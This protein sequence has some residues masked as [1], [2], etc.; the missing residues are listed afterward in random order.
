MRV[1]SKGMQRL[2]TGTLSRSL[3]GLAACGFSGSHIYSGGSIGKFIWTG[4]RLMLLVWGLPLLLAIAACGDGASTPAPRAPSPAEVQTGTVSGRVVSAG[5]G[6][7]IAG[8]TVSVGSATATTVADGSYTL[9]ADAGERVVLHVEAPSF[10]ENFRIT[11]IDAGQT[12]QLGGAQLLPIGTTQTITVA[13]G[14]T[15]AVPN[16]TAQVIIPANA[17]VPRT[18]GV[19]AAAVNVSVTPINPSIDVNY[20]PGDFTTVPAGGGTPIQI[21]TFGAQYVDIRDNSG[22]RYNLAPNTTATI[23]IPVG[24]R[25]PAQPRTIPLFYFDDS[26]GRWVE[27]GT[28]I[29]GGTLPNQYYEGTVSRLSYWNADRVQETVF[30]SGCVQDAAGQRVSNALVQTDGINYSGSASSR[31]AAD[32]SFRVALQRNSLATLVA[33]EGARITSTASVGPFSADFTMPSCLVLSSAT[34]GLSIKLTWGAGPLD[35]DSHLFVPNGNHVYFGNKGSLVNLPHANLDVDDTRS[36]GP[37]VV[38]ITRLMQGTYQYLVHNFSGT[39]NPGIISSPTRV[40]LTRNGETTVFVPSGAEDANEYWHGFNII[41]D[42]QC[43]VTIQPVN[44]WLTNPSL[45]TPIAATLCPAS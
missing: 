45:P 8:A 33:I 2:A 10:A 30:V 21:E 35:L 16:S 22:V 3:L 1:L 12:S 38:T 6:L 5:T 26:T 13:T 7:G 23:R 36:F 43:N 15:V 32:G 40:E 9:T 41:V 18:G 31:T 11:R 24:T 20:M 29:I 19:A 4:K 39:T 42:A 14:A 37:E 17:L 28:A 34:N 27:Q 44:T 25:S